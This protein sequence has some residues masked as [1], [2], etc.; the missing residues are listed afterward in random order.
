MAIHLSEPTETTAIAGDATPPTTPMPWSE[1]RRRLADAQVY[2]LA[3]T[4]ADGRPHVRPV[5]GVWVD[6]SL[7]TTTSPAARKARNLAV[8]DHCSFSVSAD[9][10]DTVLEG[11]AARVVEADHLQ[12]VADAYK[13]KYEWPPTVADGAFDAP[14][15]APT[16]G[17]PPYEIYAITPTVVYGFG[18]DEEHA[19]RST[20]WRF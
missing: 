13:A 15:G 7:H 9:G 1:A 16:A 12:R 17:P 8:N 19:P 4:A 2:W 5:L 11:T 3:T 14:Y 10:V 18:T 20:R 6:D